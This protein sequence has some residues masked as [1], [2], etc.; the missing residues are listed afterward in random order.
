MDLSLQRLTYWLR[1]SFVQI[2]VPLLGLAAALSALG[3]L[4][5]YSA[6]EH[7]LVSQMFHFAI[8]FLM[9]WAVSKAPLTRLARMAV[10]L[11]LL[12]VALLLLTIPFGITVNGA[13]RWLSLGWTRVQPSELMKIAVPLILAW[14]F[15]KN[16]QHLKAV[17]FIV[18]FILLVLPFTLIVRQ[19]DLGTAL[20][21]GAS[22]FMVIL[23]AGL[24]W[25]LVALVTLTCGVA[26]PFL[27]PMLHDYQRKRILIMLDPASDPLGAGYHIIQSTIAI[28]SGGLFGKGYLRGT[29]SQ[30]EFI[31][32]RH[33]D[34]I[35][36]V[37]A[38]EWG[39]LG[40]AV[41][42]FLYGLL[43]LRG[44]A[45][46]AAGSTSFARL[47]ASALSLSIF[48]YVFVNIGMVSGIL[49]VVGVPLPFMSY[50]GT[51]LVVFFV[52]VGILMNVGS[53]RLMIR[54]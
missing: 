13:R 20:L 44:L 40:C 8:A 26:F 18:A 10:P 29:Q 47:L 21:V 2:D 39:L 32:E 4:T 34:F 25:R 45:I 22:G 15:H 52:S 54:R 49:P 48:I 16:E 24:S 31:P 28:G 30:L 51:A 3:L 6:D 5:L 35:F 23:L 38:E 37:F 36:A 1:W 19:P 41:L 33:T 14:Y 17:H 7:R 53:H 42:L 46:G 11:Y 27:W 50:G 9:M 43:V 12:G